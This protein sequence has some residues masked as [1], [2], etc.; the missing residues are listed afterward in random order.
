MASDF[1][2]HNQDPAVRALISSPVLLPGKLTSKELHPWHLPKT[3]I[4][5]VIPVQ[6]D[7]S[8][9]AAVGEIGLDKLRGIDY[10]VQKQYFTALLQLAYDCRKPVVLHAVRSFQ[11]IFSALKPFSGLQ[12]MFHG[13]RSSPEMLDELW[14]RKITVSFHPQ[15]INSPALSAKL[16]NASGAFGF[17]SDDDPEISITQLLIEVE[18]FSGVCGLE[19]RTD[20]YFDDFLEI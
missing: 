20:Q 10:E 7:L 12:V 2:T 5:E 6:E 4:S 3:F 9:F 16:N 11:E 13:F 14:K 19:K 8:Y 15:I 18:N 17:E 1:H